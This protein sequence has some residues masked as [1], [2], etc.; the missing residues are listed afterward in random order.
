MIVIVAVAAWAM[1]GGK[2]EEDITDV[3][4]IRNVNLCHGRNHQ[5]KNARDVAHICLKKEINWSAVMNS[6]DM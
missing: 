3:K 6:V 4:I 5:Q 2:K 1:S